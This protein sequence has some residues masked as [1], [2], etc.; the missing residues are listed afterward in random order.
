VRCCFALHS[1][2]VLP[3]SSS[4]FLADPQRCFSSGWWRAEGGFLQP[5]LFTETIRAV[6]VH[7]RRCTA[8]QQTPGLMGKHSAGSKPDDRCIPESLNRTP[9]Q[10]PSRW[11]SCKMKNTL[12]P[13]SKCPLTNAVQLA[14]THT[15][16]TVSLMKIYVNKSRQ[17]EER[18]ER[19]RGMRHDHW[20]YKWKRS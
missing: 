12:R 19:E 14:H 4:L 10:K 7:R 18:T 5:T 3:L 15:H 1:G 16:T 11:V 6:R 8:M 13:T 9:S 2:L 17:A 20:G